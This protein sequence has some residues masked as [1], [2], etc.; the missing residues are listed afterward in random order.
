VAPKTVK[1]EEMKLARQVISTFEGPLNLKDYKGRIHAKDC[2]RS[3]TR[4]SRGR[5]EFVAPNVETPPKVRQPSWEA[6]GKKSLERGERVPRSVPPGRRSPRKPG[7]Q[8]KAAPGARKTLTIL[9]EAAG[10]KNAGPSFAS[11]RLGHDH[12]R[13]GPQQ[14]RLQEIPFTRRRGTS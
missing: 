1:P 3:S 5:R 14:A 4:E 8:R 6:L 12:R 2:S 10:M 7:G 9:Q 11:F 13:S